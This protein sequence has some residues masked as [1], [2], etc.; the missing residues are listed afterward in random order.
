VTEL[1]L[2]QPAI[3]LPGGISAFVTTRHGGCS[4]GPW[5]TFNL[6][7]HVQDDPAAVASNRALLKAQL[8]S[9]TGS[10]ALELQWISQVHGTAVH[11]ALEPMTESAPQADAIYTTRS[12]LA[13]GVL[14][15]DC[16]P[17][18]FYSDDDS[19]I[20]VAHA[21]WRGLQKGILENTLACFR[22]PA[23]KVGAWL[24]PAIGPCHF[25]VGPEVR[26]AFLAT[27]SAETQSA[28][29]A[30]F[31]PT[32]HHGKW[33]A[34]LYQLARIRLNAAGVIAIAGEPACTFCDSHNWYSY[35]RN[36]VTGRFAT[37]IVKTD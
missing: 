18:L 25:E 4:Q 3:S 2:Y 13:I 7:T 17:V 35:R 22:A 37:M 24:G 14:T 34:D 16:L 5:Q 28:T 21:G 36:S 31:A 6:G 26:A 1:A 11:Q 27:A 9:A 30:A 33:L 32:V 23:A 20:A 10:S 8:I 12:N 19:E 15:A 29:E